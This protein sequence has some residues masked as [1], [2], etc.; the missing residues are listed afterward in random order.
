MIRPEEN[1]QY[2]SVKE[3]ELPENSHSH[4]LKD[5]IIELKNAASKE[6]YSK[7]LC[8]PSDHRNHQQPFILDSKHH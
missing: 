5:E 1:L 4:I 3:N 6:K 7:K 2:V 8:E